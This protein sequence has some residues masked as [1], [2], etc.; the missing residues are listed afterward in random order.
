M[1]I[2]N[3]EKSLFQKSVNDI[4]TK[5]TETDLVEDILKL[6]LHKMYGESKKDSTLIDIYKLLGM[7]KFCQLIDIIN[8][9]TIKFPTKDSL[10]ETVQVAICFF[11]KN[12]KN[13]DIKD[14]SDLIIDNSTSPTKIGRKVK[15]LEDYIEKFTQIRN[16]VFH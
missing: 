12:F 8:G 1:S 4:F 15:S 9:R 6:Q 11:E 13:K 7:E 5:D 3:N 16:G 10:K 2:Y 14:T